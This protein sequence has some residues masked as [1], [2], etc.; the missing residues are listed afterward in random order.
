MTDAIFSLMTKPWSSYEEAKERS[1]RIDSLLGFEIEAC[2]AKIAAPKA[3]GREDWAHLSP[4]A[5]QTPYPELADMIRLIEGDRSVD[6]VDLGAGYGRLGLL[7]SRMRPRDRFQGFEFVD[8][9]VREGNRILANCG[10]ERARLESRDLLDSEFRM[11]TA[12]VYFIF[13]FGQ[14]AQ[15]DVILGNLRELSKADP[16]A[17]FGRGRATR[18]LIATSHAW[19]SQVEEPLHTEH[20]SLYRSAENSLGRKESK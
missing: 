5:F 8:E 20:W 19:L 9:R 7:L 14:P 4:Q 10:C 11:P 1:A 12:D 17:V 18:H 13:D 3:Q 16:I 15:I 6:W 2:E